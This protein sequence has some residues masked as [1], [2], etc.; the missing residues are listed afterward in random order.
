MYAAIPRDVDE[1]DQPAGETQAD[2][3]EA[4]ALDLRYPI[5]LQQPVS[6]AFGMESVQLVIGKGTAP[7]ERRSCLLLSIT[8]HTGMVPDAAAVFSNDLTAI[9]AHPYKVPMI[10]N[11]LQKGWYFTSLT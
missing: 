8:L 5:V 11:L 3:A 10:M 7:F 4:V 2:P 9:G 6:E 1:A